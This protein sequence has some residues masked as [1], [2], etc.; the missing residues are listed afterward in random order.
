MGRLNRFIA[1]ILVLFVLLAV[2][3]PRAVGE[4]EQQARS[5]VD[6]SALQSP[7][8]RYPF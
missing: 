3:L 2:G 7:V 5:A 4:E 8:R 1:L 6:S